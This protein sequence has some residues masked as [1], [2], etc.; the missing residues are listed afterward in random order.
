MS[1]I[2]VLICRVDD[3]ERMTEVAAFE[4]AN[5]DE[6]RRE[7][8]HA[9]DDLEL[10][11]HRTG[12]A[13]LRRLL[14][15]QWALIDSALADQYVTQAMPGAV[16]RDGQAGITVASRFGLVELSRQIC[17]EVDTQRHVMPGNA[18]LP[19]HQGML[20]TRGLQEW[21]C[22]LSQDV[23]FASAARLLSWQTQEAQ[24]LSS[25]T[26]RTL[27]REH[28]QIIRQAEQAEV[29]LLAQQ[30][31]PSGK[32][33]VVP[34]HAPRQRAGWPAAL[35]E[36][37]DAALAAEQA[38]PPDGV[39][40]ADWTRVLAVRRAEAS[41]TAANLRQLGPTLATHEV[42]LAIDEVLTRQPAPHQFWEL[43]TARLDTAAGYR[44]V[45][46][47]GLAFLQHV[48]SMIGLAVGPQHAFLLIADGARWI[49]TFFTQLLTGIANRAMILDWYHLHQKC[50]AYCRRI[51]PDPLERATLSR[52]LARRLWQG[53]VPSALRLL[54]RYRPRAHDTHALDSLI[55]YLQARQ[56]WIPN[57][58]QR[59][60]EQC[61]IGS[62]R[63]EKANDLL[64][65]KRQKVGGRQW[66][67][68]SSDSL[69]ALR[70]LQLNDGW[71]RYWEQGEVLP[72]VA[73]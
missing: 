26:L 38:Y 12:N 61:Y 60:L 35:N 4:L 20:I 63:A 25:T 64:V 66:S 17:T 56:A 51:C 8:A 39:S 23:S 68:L 21:A 7:A 58:R 24:I 42:Q 6:V 50:R 48:L 19:A 1:H 54:S 32:L 33:Q 45:S 47:T 11:T 73:C 10:R 28:G 52:R 65:A 18:L 69:A 43:R 36:A 41:R 15:A 2:R 13:I 34:H 27:V 71:D 29:A 62:G 40:W 31:D 16:R 49:R 9:L 72:L 30:P 46:G 59:R 57:Y 37:V 3:E 5:G 44:Y 67:L 53:N 22:L 55:T 14:Q 70:T